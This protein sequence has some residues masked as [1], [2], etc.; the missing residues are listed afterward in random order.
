MAVGSRPSRPLRRAFGL[1]SVLMSATVLALSSAVD[2]NDV[3]IPTVPAAS[4]APMTGYGILVLLMGLSAVATS[5]GRVAALASGERRGND[6]EQGVLHALRRSGWY[7]ADHVVLPHVDVDH[8]AIGPAGIL[9]VQTRWTN[10]SDH[11]GQPAARARVAAHQLR[12]ALAAC[13]IDVEVVPAVLTFGPGLP[14]EPGGVKVIDAVAML[15]GYQAD[16]W[17]DELGQRSL[18]SSATVDAVRQTV[19]D[20][21]EQAPD[22]HVGMADDRTP[23]R[24]P[25]LVR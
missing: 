14:D 24:R 16:V 23:T 12:R 6:P 2:N 5:F 20:L 3:G 7:V 15:N 11:R 10:R 1:A 17:L 4:Q 21:R 8:V 13:E 18:L 25:V 22:A 19:G 9:A